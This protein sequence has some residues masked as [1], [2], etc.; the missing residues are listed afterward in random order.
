MYRVSAAALTAAREVLKRYQLTPRPGDFPGKV[1]GMTGGEAHI[2][3]VI[4]HATSIYKISLLRPEIFYWQTALRSRDV[5]PI[6][7]ETFLKKVVVTFAEIPQYSPKDQAPVAYWEYPVDFGPGAP[8]RIPLTKSAVE[9]AR[10]LWYYYLV[11]PH[12]N[13]LPTEEAERIILAQTVEAGLSLDRVVG[14]ACRDAR[15]VV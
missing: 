13:P 11:K 10:Y 6:Q 3:I 7:I 4:D 12:A 15:A 9:A 14:A 2:A 8:H 5:D 1:N